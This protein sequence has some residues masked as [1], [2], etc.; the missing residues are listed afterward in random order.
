MRLFEK[1]SRQSASIDVKVSGQVGGSQ[2]V[3]FSDGFVVIE[4]PKGL[5]RFNTPE[6]LVSQVQ[7]LIS[8]DNRLD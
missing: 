3:V 6:E 8:A 7:P 2:Y 4:T 5:Y 1:L